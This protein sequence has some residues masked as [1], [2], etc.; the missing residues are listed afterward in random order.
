[1]QLV[2]AHI[3]GVDLG[4]A[5][6]EQHFGEAAGRGADIERHPALR[7]QAE[8]FER[9]FELET[10]A[11]DVV[12]GARCHGK[13]RI[14]GH[15]GTGLGRGLAR[16]GDTAPA[17]EVGGAGAGGRKAQLPPIVGRCAFFCSWPNAV[18]ICSRRV[19]SPRARMKA[20][21][22]RRRLNIHAAKRPA[23]RVIAE[24]S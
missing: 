14:L 20:G 19:G 23:R 13:G 10:A 12:A 7:V 2:A 4:R 5:A 24:V 22:G 16:H 11:G 3:N 1:M 9:G 18:L 21:S 15:Q 17:H 8:G 6:G